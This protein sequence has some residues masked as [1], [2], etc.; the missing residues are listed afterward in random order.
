MSARVHSTNISLFPTIHLPPWHML[1]L[2]YVD[3]T[4]TVNPVMAICGVNWYPVSLCDI[5]YR[6]SNS[7]TNKQMYPRWHTYTL[8]SINARPLLPPIQGRFWRN[9]TWQPRGDGKIEYTT[10]LYV[11][12]AVDSARFRWHGVGWQFGGSWVCEPIWKRCQ[13]NI[14]KITLLAPYH[15]KLHTYWAKRI[16][17]CSFR[18]LSTRFANRYA[19]FYTPPPPPH[20]HTRAPPPPHTWGGGGNIP[21][22]V[23]V[24][25]WH[26]SYK[27]LCSAICI[28]HEQ[29]FFFNLGLHLFQIGSHTQLRPN[30]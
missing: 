9:I 25:F 24:A 21:M 14:E 20:T 2:L 23:C 1:A 27:H 5:S 22:C 19:G 16:K 7:L 30:F 10:I 17:S 18:A 28:P 26:H 15:I 12:R 3:A 8:G 4:V 13:P 29:C 6:N 11:S